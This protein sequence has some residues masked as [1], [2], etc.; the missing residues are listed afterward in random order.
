[1]NAAAQRF[2]ASNSSYE[3]HGQFILGQT[4]VHAMR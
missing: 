2:V 4:D 1:M 3:A